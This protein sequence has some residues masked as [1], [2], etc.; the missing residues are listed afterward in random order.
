MFNVL[1]R[2][3][4]S[5]EKEVSK[6]NPLVL[7]INSLEEKIKKLKDSDFPKKTKEF[8]ER[9]QDGEPLELILPESFA[10]VREA[11]RRTIG[12][13]HFDVQLMA[14]AVL[15]S[16]KIAE[17]KT[18]EGKTLSAVPALYLH[19]LTGKSVHLVTVN[20]YLARRDA[21]WM[22]P[23]FKFLGL[24]V[25]SIISEE[26]FIFDPSYVNKNTH[27]F[28]LSHLKTITRKEA[29]E[30]DVVYG[31]NSEYGFDYLRDNMA[32][33][34][35]SVVQRGY[36]FAVVD[37][38]DSVLIDEAR[39]PHI[40]S[41]PDEEPTQKYYEYSRLVEKLTP[42]IDYKIDEKLRT[43][44]LTDHGITKIEKMF[45]VSDIYEKDFDTVYHLEAA[46]KARTLFHKEKDYIVK[47]GEV[48]LVD[49]FTGRLMIGRRLSEGL[50]QAIEA[51]ENVAI[52]RESKT[53]AT[54]SLQNYFRMY[55]K[56]AGMTGTAVTEAEEFHKIYK[57]DVVAIP[58]HK[59]LIRK[60]HADAIYKTGR[61]K[62]SAV[63]DEIEKAHKNGQ[64]VLVGTTSIDKNEIVSEL[65]RRRG[66]KHEILNAK[67]HEREAEIIAKAGEKGAVTVAT[68]MAGRGVD[69]I[70]GGDNPKDENGMEKKETK[71]WEVWEKKHQDVLDAGGLLVIGTERHE[72]RR[73][74]NQ[75]RG[76]SGRQ[77]D[78]GVSR[79]FVGLDD[80][81]MR[82][83]GGESISG[84]MTKF[85]MPE[86][87]PLQHPLVS[88]AIEQAQIKVE[89][90]NFD[91]R[92]HLVEY[93][94][95]LNKQREIIYQR[96]RK[97]LEAGEKGGESLKGE[98]EEKI[99]QSISET[100]LMQSAEEFQDAEPASAK[101]SEKFSTIVPFDEASLKQIASQLEQMH[102][103]EDKTSFLTTIAKDVY[104][105]RE[106]Q[107]GGELMRQVERFVMLSV[108]DNLWMDHL[109][110]IENLRQGIGLR[111][112]GQK[113]PLV[114]YK[115]E[116]YGM[117]EKLID[118][119]DD[120]IVHRIYKIQVQQAPHQNGAGQAPVAPVP[121]QHVHSQ[122][123]ESNVVSEISSSPKPIKSATATTIDKKK[124]GRNDPCPCGKTDPNTGKPIKYKKCHYPQYG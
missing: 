107:M 60:D 48:I 102:S 123:A 118:T 44:H 86:D 21:G 89:G 42:E 108:M 112:Y 80:D 117:F 36:Y 24:S 96:R 110:A 84:I 121:H 85:N 20:D 87:V 61:A 70:L 26:S 12:Q 34:L 68:N 11:A 4:D 52:Q 43:A 46:L 9:V 18:G 63:A 41:A 10:L 39:T 106:E 78:P 49:E 82:L 30:A 57:L 75:L 104:K 65:L 19:S 83:F 114:E 17:Q 59:D 51:K 31:I 47:D 115:N 50:H 1:A 45:G 54:V 7:E 81:I 33:D 66:I 122:P 62:L 22:G 124:L 8:K 103:T 40:I 58:T 88:R 95:V 37:E 76:R 93:D 64:P 77:G 74:D 105:T 120:E 16:G 6:L 109:D 79:F 113:D 71:E 67:N 25:S 35:N 99:E 98:I 91:I 14:A 38:V 13:R 69:I 56:L 72:S 5:N 53:L 3:F 92:K 119:I 15:A 97:V 28:R 55:E 116:A 101:L 32:Q 73:I 94:D 27:D 23:V 29:Y 111:G 100:V 2:F 90:Y